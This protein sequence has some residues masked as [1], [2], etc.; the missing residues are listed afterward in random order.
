MT[1]VPECSPPVR[2]RMPRQRWLETLG[3]ASLPVFC[4]HLVLV[5]VVLAGLGAKYDRPWGVDLAL[6]VAS[7]AALY[8]VA[9]ATLWLEKK[10]GADTTPPA[11]LAPGQKRPPMHPPASARQGAQPKPRDPPKA[12]VAPG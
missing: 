2:P 5:L 12:K 11:V 3:S 6:L 9:R 7:F 4:A 1:H 8:A 10:P